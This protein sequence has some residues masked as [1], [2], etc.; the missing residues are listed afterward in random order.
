MHTY[1]LGSTKQSAHILRVLKQIEQEDQREFTSLPGQAKH[2]GPI[3]VGV[4][5]HLGSQALVIALQP[6][7]LLSRHTLY[8]Y[9]RLVSQSY[10]L[11]KDPPFLQALGQEQATEAAPPRQQ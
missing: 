1:C 3:S 10:H 9:P 11:G 8:G 6:V 2:L 4:R 7:Q 5:T